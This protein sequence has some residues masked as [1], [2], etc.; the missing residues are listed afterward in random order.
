MKTEMH[1]QYSFSLKITEWSLLIFITTFSYSTTLHKSN[2]HLQFKL[3]AFL[4]FYRAAG[5]ISEHL[6]GIY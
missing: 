1:F 3:S 5:F 6:C 2:L 4:M